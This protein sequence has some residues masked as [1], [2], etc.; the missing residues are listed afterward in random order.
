[1][2]TTTERGQPVRRWPA[3]TSGLNAYAIT[4]AT[5][6]GPRTSR[7][8]HRTTAAATSSQTNRPRPPAPTA[9]AVPGCVSST[10]RAAVSV[11]GWPAIALL[12][13]ARDAHAGEEPAVRRDRI[14]AGGSGGPVADPLPKRDERRQVGLD[15]PSVV[16]L[17]GDGR[18]NLENA[19]VARSGAFDGSRRGVPNERPRAVRV[20]RRGSVRPESILHHDALGP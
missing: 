1:M 2:P 9:S 18:R 17:D 8:S 15:R 4:A 7:A 6:N 19:V 11:T 3:V 10:G 20:E 5:M 12:G 16:D 13:K 14:R